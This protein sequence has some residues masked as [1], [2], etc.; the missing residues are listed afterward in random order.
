MAATSKDGVFRI[1][2]TNWQRVPH[3]YRLP[4]ILSSCTAVLLTPS[5]WRRLTYR[6]ERLPS[7]RSLPPPSLDDSSA[8]LALP[9][10][11]NIGYAQYGD[12]NGTPVITLHG[13]LGSRIENELFDA[14]AKE[15]GIRIIGIDRPG[16][17]FSSPDPRPLKNRKVV[18]HAKDVEALAEHLKLDEYA[19]IGM[20]GGGPYALGCAHSLPS[21]PSKP[22]LKVVSVVTGLQLPDMKQNY[23]AWLV[24][25]HRNLNVRWVIK[26]MFTRG[27]AWQLHLSDDERAEAMHKEFDVKKAHP[28][29]IAV[30]KRSDYP[31]MMRIFLQSARQAAAQGWNGFLDDAAIL[32]ADPG[33]RIEDIRADLPVQLWY[34]MEDTNISPKAGEETAERLRAGGNTLVE[35]HEEEG[36]T[37]GST[38]VN[39]QRSIL[40][41]L[42]RAMK[43]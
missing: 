41:D 25:V 12:L 10:G 30:A 40:E 42:V 8:K 2:E 18:D 35:L 32:S 22:R 11:R 13:M 4:L 23:P 20:S 34:G 43:G 16:I 19:I 26:W 27:A 38:Q 28:A 21:A 1:L 6:P 17:G 31:N 7:Q 9:D 15:L 36:Q 5:L 14:N 33:F 3:S 24:F 39:Y 37:H 29:D